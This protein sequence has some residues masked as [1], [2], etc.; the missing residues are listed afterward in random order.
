MPEL[1]YG[2]IHPANPPYDEQSPNWARFMQAVGIE[3]PSPSAVGTLD[4]D[5][6]R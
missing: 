2:R 3:D 6:S 5:G 1:D 4:D